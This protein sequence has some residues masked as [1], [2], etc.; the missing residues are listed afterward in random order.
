M[1]LAYKICGIVRRAKMLDKDVHVSD[2]QIKVVE[3]GAVLIN[4]KTREGMIIAADKSDEF[5]SE[6]SIAE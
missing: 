3:Q 5:S 4:L 6:E 2:Y 1:S